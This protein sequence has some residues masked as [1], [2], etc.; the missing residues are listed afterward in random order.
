LYYN[1]VYI[2]IPTMHLTKLDVSFMLLSDA[3]R[4]LWEHIMLVG[5]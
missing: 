1:Y 2:R 5:V 3:D 4:R